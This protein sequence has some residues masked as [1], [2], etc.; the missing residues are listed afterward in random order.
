[1]LEIPCISLDYLDSFWFRFPSSL[2]PLSRSS[3]II[4][5]LQL[6]PTHIHQ[7][8][9]LQFWKMSLATS[10][11]IPLRRPTY[12]RLAVSMAAPWTFRLKAAVR[13]WGIAN[14]KR[15]LSDFSTVPSLPL[16]TQRRLTTLSQFQDSLRTSREAEFDCKWLVKRNIN[17]TKGIIYKW[18]T[19]TERGFTPPCSPLQLSD[20]VIFC[21]LSTSWCALRRSSSSVLKSS[22]TCLAPNAASG[23]HFGRRTSFFGFCLHLCMVIQCWE[24][25]FLIQVWRKQSADGKKHLFHPFLLQ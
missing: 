3:F 5:A 25:V 18:H 6:I 7:T 10:N 17:K 1:M 12:S 8:S 23:P 11:L 2:K 14:Q 22:R 20:L 15:H 24:Y 19:R 9:C 13:L 4:R 21:H 16:A